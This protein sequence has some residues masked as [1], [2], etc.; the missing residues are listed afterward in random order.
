MIALFPVPEYGHRHSQ[1]TRA[2]GHLVGRRFDPATIAAVMDA[3][4]A[5]FQGQGT[6]R[7]GHAEAA[8]ELVTCLTSTVR[9]LQRGKFRPAASDL[10]HVALCRQILL[11]ANQQD[12]LAT[13]V[14]VTDDQG[15][16]TLVPGQRPGRGPSPDIIPYCKR[17][18]HIGVHLCNSDDERAFVE[19]LVI[20]TMHKILHT[21]EYLDDRVI[22]MTQDQIRQ[23][24]GSRHEARN[25]GPQQ[26]ERLKCKYLTRD[27]DGK[28]T[29]RFELLREIRKG[30]RKRGQKSGEPSA[31]QPTGVMLLL[32]ASVVQK[33]GPCSRPPA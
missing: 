5:H 3:W 1:M 17:V 21:R 28:P 11:D 6:V 33:A 13:G 32:P 23:I 15:Q 16:R 29:T 8:S 12:L 10:D 31:Y 9:S 7:T 27:G 25:W 19:A 20:Q 26:L 30:F 22:Q 14:I 24:A 2:V 4:Y 18:T